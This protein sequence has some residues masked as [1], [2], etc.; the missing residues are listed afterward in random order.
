[1]VRNNY[2]WNIEKEK[3]I[4][5]AKNNITNILKESKDNDIELNELIFLLNNRTKKLDL[6][7]N[8]KKKTLSNF[9][10]V[11]CK[12][13]LQFLNDYDDYFVIKKNNKIYIS[14]NNKKKLFG[15]FDEWL[16]INKE[17]IES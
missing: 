11:V 3:G 1:M 12:G 16:F 15:E 2:K 17:N 5:I 8:N 6:K 4:L 10:K 13:I 9:L 7:N 14:Y